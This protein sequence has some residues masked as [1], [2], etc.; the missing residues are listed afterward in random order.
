M[1]CWGRADSGQLGIGSEWIHETTSGVIGVE[2]PRRVGGH[3]EGRRTVRAFV[4]VVIG[5]IALPKVL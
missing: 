5:W 1:F 3:L 2:W 4:S